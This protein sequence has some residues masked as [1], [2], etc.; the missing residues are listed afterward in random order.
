M[1]PKVQSPIL[2]LLLLTAALLQGTRQLQAAGAVTAYRFDFGAPWSD[3]IQ[4]PPELA[5]SHATRWF[6][7]NRVT[8]P[9]AD[10]W[11]GIHIWSRY[12]PDLGYGWVEFPGMIVFR[13]GPLNPLF[14]RRESDP[15]YPMAVD[16]FVVNGPKPAVF[17]V[18]LPPGEYLL[19]AYLGDLSLGESRHALQVEANGRVIIQG[20]TT[21]GGRLS[22]VS[23]AVRV[24]AAP[25]ILS[26]I[27]LR[28]EGPQ[29]SMSGLEIQPRPEHTELPPVRYIPHDPP[30][31]D[32]AVSNFAMWIRV[33]RRKWQAAQAAIEARGLL[34][35]TLPRLARAPTAT[36]IYLSH[37]GN[38]GRL[39][40][41]DPGIDLTPFV[42]LLQELGADVVSA[43]HAAV[44]R[45]L[46]EGNLTVFGSTH[47]ER[48]QFADKPDLQLFR[49]RD[50]RTEQRDG[51]FC[52]HSPRNQQRL[53]ERFLQETSEQMS[54]LSALF[55]DEPR[56]MS[57][58]GPYQGDYS[59][60]AAD[61][62]TRW[63]EAEGHPEWAAHGI[64]HPSMSMPF[65]A[66]YRF[67]LHSVALFLRG[68][69]QG[70]ELESLTLF[71]GNG[72]IGPAVW[73]HST[74]YPPAMAKAGMLSASWNY[75]DA[76]SAKASAEVIAATRDFEGEG[77][78]FTLMGSDADHGRILATA[79]L[80]A[81]PALLTPYGQLNYELVAEV[82]A[83]ARALGP[84][85]RNCGVYRY[86]PEP[87][88]FPDLVN[89]EKAEGELWNAHSKQLF[90]QNIDYRVTYTAQTPTPSMLIYASITPVLS[91]RELSD[92]KAYL[93][94]GGVLIYA[95]ADGPVSP[96]GEP[97]G[98][99]QQLFGTE[100]TRRVVAADAF[101]SGARIR[102]LAEQ[103]GVPL[104]PVPAV[105][106]ESVVKTF[107]FA[108][109]G[110]PW[111]LALNADQ[112]GAHQ[113]A[114]PGRW[115][116]RFS[117]SKV[118]SAAPAALPPGGFRLL[119]GPW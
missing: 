52:I 11:T 77:G 6:L 64:P 28:P 94:R 69:V 119:L 70:T 31:D 10:G 27:S 63:C 2:W 57:S 110:R 15:I 72:E 55:I 111:A 39:L 84:A 38:F 103:H 51:W 48:W 35:Q 50:G 4:P 116:D 93:Q 74:F 115:Q 41:L 1:L 8:T 56:G 66:F 112:N 90:E 32:M 82:S 43:R 53:R 67:R 95:C 118:T 92:L 109:H 102:Q 88:V 45:Q 98:S 42:L 19:T 89:F 86:C 71:P 29:F 80:S 76:W 113:V 96:A 87:L 60:W 46:A 9:L 104:N 25:L 22:A 34:G 107:A 17:R 24:D 7:S 106:E 62:F 68:I 20:V 59:A 79:A 73:N 12:D 33:E 91:E 13:D 37:A 16:G 21:A 61:A 108:C 83:L 85:R 100:L 99:L 81:K 101:P 65:Y 3:A 14:S 36:R 54:H 105:G 26:F 18:D 78:V 97:Q 117:G 58:F 30:A 49:T 75:Y 5:T 44:A 47:A 40:A 114:L 23:S